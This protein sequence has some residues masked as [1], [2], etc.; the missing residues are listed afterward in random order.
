MRISPLALALCVV[1]GSAALSTAQI[2]E[3]RGQIY[4]KEAAALCERD[5]GRLWGV[6]LC[7]P[8][9]FADPLTKTISTSQPL[10]LEIALGGLLVSTDGETLTVPAPSSAG[11]STLTGDGWALTIAPG[12]A[13][14]PG[15]RAGDLRVVRDSR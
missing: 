6:S 11:G 12:W 10:L 5:G 15:P 1:L 13:A 14:R 7:G 2:D 9:V 4:F 8:M 3:Q